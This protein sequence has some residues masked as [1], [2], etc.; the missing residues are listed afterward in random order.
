MAEEP[1]QIA[2][3]NGRYHNRQIDDVLHPEREPKSALDE[4]A[5]TMGSMEFSAQ[6]QP[7]PV[8]RGGNLVKSAWLRYQEEAP[9]P[10]DADKIIVSWDTAQSPGQSADY[11]ACVVLMVKGEKIYILEVMRARLEYPDLKRAVLESNDRWREV[12]CDDFELVIEKSGAGLSLIQDLH[13]ED[14]YPI[15]IKPDGDKNMRMSAQTAKFEA[16]AV[17]LPTQAPWLEE[18]KKELLA[19][20]LGRHDDQIDALSQALKR[21]HA[22]GP[23]SVITGSYQVVG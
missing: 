9:D 16:G 11:S 15:G 8:P 18:F 5:K 3:G 1:T 20:P 10:H 23:P 22:P 7:A 21:A 17:H 4:L 6:Y 2:L 12:G 13:E 14:I 19:F